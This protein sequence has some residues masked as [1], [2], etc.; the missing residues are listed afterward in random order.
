MFQPKS[1]IS[2]V[3]AGRWLAAERGDGYVLAMLRR[4]SPSQSASARQ[5]NLKVALY[6]LSRC[7]DRDAKR[8]SSMVRPA[9]G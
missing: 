9:P 6:R 1:P 8:G 3:L 4:L 5:L 7:L 2:A